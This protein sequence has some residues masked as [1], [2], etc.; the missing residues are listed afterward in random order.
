MK[1][2]LTTIFLIAGLSTIY[3]QAPTAQ[4]LRLDIYTWNLL[5]RPGVTYIP[6]TQY[7]RP[8]LEFYYY[9]QLNQ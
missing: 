4:Q 6:P 9:N 2:I 1:N 8:L 7:P 5:V 3:S